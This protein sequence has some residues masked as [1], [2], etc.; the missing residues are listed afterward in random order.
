MKEKE[1]MFIMK[2]E[3]TFEEQ[4]AEYKEQ[5]KKR[6]HEAHKQ[7]EAFY[8]LSPNFIKAPVSGIAGKDGR[9]YPF[10]K[11]NAAI[12]MQAALDKGIDDT[13]WLSA[14][15]VHDNGLYVQ[16]GEKATTIVAHNAKTHEPNRLISYF[17]VQQLAESSRK[18]VPLAGPSN[19]RDAIAQNMALQLKDTISFKKGDDLFTQFADAL[20][21]GYSK[22]KELDRQWA[23]KRIAAIDAVDLGEPADTVEMK[24]MQEAKKVR[25][26]NPDAKNYMYQATVQVLKEGIYD[27]KEIAEALNKVSPTPTGLDFD[28]EYGQRTVEFALKNDRELN[29]Q[30]ML[31]GSR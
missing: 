14:K 26:N 19:F 13:R 8:Q 25:C 23:E 30:R 9:R 17:N 28:K 12:L 18:K 11:E 1:R 3:R 24:L 27:Q 6:F 5:I 21:H 7:N 2:D 15:Q 4:Y 16:K 29:R 10:T 20:E 22:A 31:A